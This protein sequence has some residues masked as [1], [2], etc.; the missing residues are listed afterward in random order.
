MSEAARATLALDRDCLVVQVPLRI[1]RRRGR[2]EIIVPGG[3]ESAAADQV[4]R[5]QGQ[6]VTVARALA[7]T[8]GV[9]PLRQHPRA[10]ARCGRRQLLPGAHAAAHAARAR[11]HRVHP[12]RD[13]ARRP[14]A[15]ETLPGARG[16]G[17]AEEN[18][19][20]RRPGPLNAATPAGCRQT[21]S[22]PPSHGHAD[23]WCSRG[24]EG[25]SV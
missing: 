19:G 22:R 15:G 21:H 14:L 20:A 6:A 13:G 18:A 4:R 8:A 16:V 9:R 24:G 3:V 7:G 5:K 1:K 17:R 11:Y 12:A 23:V 10:G 2:K 25:R